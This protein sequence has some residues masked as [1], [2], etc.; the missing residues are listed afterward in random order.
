MKKNWLLKDVNG[1]VLTSLNTSN[2]RDVKQMFTEVNEV[3]N[4]I[5]TEETSYANRPWT[6]EEIVIDETI[7]V[8]VG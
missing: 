7:E 2:D 5:N 4:H 3:N 1:K 8:L 6:L